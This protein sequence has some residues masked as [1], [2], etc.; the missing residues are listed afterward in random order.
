MKLKQIVRLWRRW[1]GYVALRFCSLIIYLIPAASIRHIAKI[2][3]DIGYILAGR[4]R[5]IAINTLNLAFGDSIDLSQKSKIAKDSF[6]FMAAGVLELLFCVE[7]HDYVRK[8][9]RIEGRDYLDRALAKKKGVI[10]VTAHF[11]NFALMQFSLGVE[12]YLVNSIIRH[13]RDPQTNRYFLKK[14]NEI[15]VKTIY[16]EPRNACVIE[17]LRSLKNNEVLFLLLDQ[18][19][20]TGG[21]FVDFFGR[22]AATA[23]GPI[24]LAQRSGAAI[25]PMFMVHD[26]KERHR[27][28]IEPEF[29]LE[30]APDNNQTVLLNI[31]RLTNII[32]DYIRRYPAEW[33]W[34][35]RRWK[36][37][38]QDN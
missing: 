33:S 5:K 4:H 26:N 28:I 6:R 3:S 23:T 7:H 15:G 32:E 19:F 31:Q 21:I 35:H 18:N 20:G 16:T 36:T 30:E 10:A 12:G 1:L 13:M 27:L 14:R 24:V 2:I 37:R 11:G 9:V 29:K 34:I 25:L 17:S 22:K 8:I 38:P